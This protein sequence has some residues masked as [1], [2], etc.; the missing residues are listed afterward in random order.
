MAYAESTLPLW[1]EKVRIRSYD[2][3]FRRQASIEAL[4][5]YFLE[6]AW[7][8][9]EALGFGY[10]HLAA[11]QR[12]W[13][14]ARLVIQVNARPEWG[15]EILLCTWPRPARSILALRDFEML[16]ADGSQLLGGSSAWLVLDSG[17]RR[18]QRLDGLLCDTDAFSDRMAIGRDPTKLSTAPDL[19]E[20][21]AV[22][23]KYSD[24]DVNGHVNSARYIGWVLDSFPMEFHNQH[25][26]R[27]FEVNYVG[28]TTGNA[29]LSV[30]SGKASS[31]DW[32]H[33]I[34]KVNGEEA[35]RARS[36]WVGVEGGSTAH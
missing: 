36:E 8:H 17:S 5:R 11:Q 27:L 12:F 21:M 35:C 30:R 20:T 29:R 25:E 16:D 26:L 14:L 23:S 19:P 22:A 3:D 18:P 6:A 28:E 7:N 10:S 9:A 4:C 2:V 1:K 32:H 34:V 33:A 13:V 31:A 15:D 24:I